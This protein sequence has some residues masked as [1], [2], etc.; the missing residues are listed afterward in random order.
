MGAPKPWPTRW[1]E[2]LRVPFDP[3][4]VE[5]PLEDPDYEIEEDPQETPYWLPE[6]QL[7]LYAVTWGVTRRCHLRCRHCYDA[8]GQERADLSTAEALMTVDRLAQAG[9]TF[10]AFSGGEPLL[11]KDL[12]QLM[13]YA[14]DQQ[15]GVGLRTNATLID[16]DVAR[17]LAALPLGVAGVSLDGATEPTHDA[18]R[19]EGA[20]RRSMQGIHELLDAGIRVT[21]EVVLGRHNAHESLAL[22]QLAEHM[23]V[24][25]IN[26]SALV[27]RG[28]A[29]SSQDLLDHGMWRELTAA[30][31]GASLAAKVTVSPSCAL[32]GNC[33]ACIEPNITCEGWVTPCFLATRKL[34]HILDTPPEDIAARLSLFRSATIGSC[35]RERWI[36]SRRWQALA[37]MPV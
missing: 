33:W 32:W 23:G 8:T 19:G 15:I 1:A 18:V 5:E 24:D 22:V 3:D 11:R 30:L 9:I 6:E 13:T 14:R 35:G 12:F 26:F 28:R 7:P 20:F 27:P 34:F 16:A 4:E 37:A 36:R 17:Q 31:Y 25:E 29:Q 21:V 2:P 10:I